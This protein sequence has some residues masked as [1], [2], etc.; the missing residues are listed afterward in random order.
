MRWT[1]TIS[2]MI[3]V[4]FSMPFQTTTA[5]GQTTGELYR[6]FLPQ[7]G[8]GFKNEPPARQK[9]LLKALDGGVSKCGKVGKKAVFLD[10]DAS[11]PNKHRNPP[12]EEMTITRS[13]ALIQYICRDFKAD[14][15]QS[16]Y[17]IYKPGSK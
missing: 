16:S 6:K 4:A 2:L 9:E 7:N 10:T 14:T 12:A 8:Q 13:G 15:S 11:N 17:F 1:L 3:V 5:V